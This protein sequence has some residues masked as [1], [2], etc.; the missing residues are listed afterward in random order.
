MSTE[1]QRGRDSARRAAQEPESDAVATRA[2]AGPRKGSRE[3]RSASER[4]AL[5]M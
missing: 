5:L 1:I 2:H 3:L 4:P